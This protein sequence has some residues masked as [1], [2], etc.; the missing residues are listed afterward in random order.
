[1]QV[2]QQLDSAKK[3]STHHDNEAVV[4]FL[5]NGWVLDAFQMAIFQTIFFVLQI[6]NFSLALLQFFCYLNTRAVTIRR[7]FWHE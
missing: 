1:M 6:N 5:V 4:D 2:M 3:S 7:T